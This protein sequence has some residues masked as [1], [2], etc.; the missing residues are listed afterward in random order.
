MES[1]KIIFDHE[2][3]D[4]YRVSLE[5]NQFVMHTLREED[6]FHR[7]I[8]D[9]LIRASMSIPLNI[10]EGNGKRSDAD[11]RR[12]FEIAR[13]SAMECAAIL[14]IVAIANASFA[15]KVNIGKQLLQRVVAMLSKMTAN[16]ADRLREGESTYGDTTEEFEHDDEHEHEHD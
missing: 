10:A 6:S 8:W 13:G 4:V 16:L 9:Q 12:F 1:P 5:F 3:L 7:S 11:R 14:D 15:E 2:R